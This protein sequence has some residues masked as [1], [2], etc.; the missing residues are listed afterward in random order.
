MYSTIQRETQ[1]AHCVNR[2]CGADLRDSRS[3]RVGLLLV[4]PVPSGQR[5]L[6]AVCDD[7]RLYGQLQVKVL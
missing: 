4:S 3:G 1:T 6:E 7:S 2:V 5:V